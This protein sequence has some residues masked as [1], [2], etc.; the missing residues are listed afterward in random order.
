MPAGFFGKVPCVGDFVKRRLAPEFVTAWDAW[1]QQGM[2][3]SREQVG[4][5]WHD[6][7]LTSPVWRFALGGGVAGADPACGVMVP[8]MDRVGRLFPLTVAD[9]APGW[10]VLPL[11]EGAGAW[12]AS[13]EAAAISAVT[14]EFGELEAFDAAVAG[15]PEPGTPVD[16]PPAASRVAGGAWRAALPEGGEPGAAWR[17]LALAAMGP[18]MPRAVFW[19]AGSDL[20]APGLLAFNA[21]PGPG[22]FRWLLDGGSAA[23]GEPPWAAVGA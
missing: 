23:T 18:D 5:G 19:T 12:F 22:H 15:L 9:V 17:P 10:Q 3:A 1:L 13:A 6:L 21:L 7:F 16:W 2:H 8:S 14:G 4:A 20:V 11:V